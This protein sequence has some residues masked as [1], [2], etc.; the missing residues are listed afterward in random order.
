MRCLDVDQVSELIVRY[1]WCQCLH[2]GSRALHCL[3][4]WL[5]VWACACVFIHLHACV[6]VCLLVSVSVFSGCCWLFV[7]VLV[8]VCVYLCLFLC[9]R[10]CCV[11][12]CL[13]LCLYPVFF[14]C[15]VECSLHVLCCVLFVLRVREKAFYIKP[16]AG[17]VPSF[18]WK[19]KFGG[20]F[21]PWNLN[22]SGIDNMF[23]LA[24]S[25]AG[26]ETPVPDPGQSA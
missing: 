19:D 3:M 18:R 17:G 24:K 4:V 14:V 7:S 6:C 15:G 12:V 1:T 5:C 9:L 16:V 2:V 11:V 25:I 8:S 21:L 23:L 26:W 10:V 13:C 22:D 20:V